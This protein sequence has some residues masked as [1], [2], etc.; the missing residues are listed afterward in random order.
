MSKKILT[1]TQCSSFSGTFVKWNSCEMIFVAASDLSNISQI[2]KSKFYKNFE[3]TGELYA[4][5]SCLNSIWHD[6]KGNILVEE[7]EMLVIGCKFSVRMNKFWAS[8][9]LMVIT[10]N[11]LYFKITVTGSE[12]Y[13][14]WLVLIRCMCV[15][16]SECHVVYCKYMQIFVSYTLIK[17][18]R[19]EKMGI[20]SFLKSICYLEITGILNLLII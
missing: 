8:I 3:T 6:D 17:L 19:K 15:H 5:W 7:D 4:Y 9:Y 14:R 2:G 20:F 11:N 12:M 18:L 13:L 16:L 1:V 10:F